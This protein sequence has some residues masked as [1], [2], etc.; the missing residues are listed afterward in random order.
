MQIFFKRKEALSICSCMLSLPGE[1]PSPELHCEK[2]RSHKCH[3]EGGLV[4]SGY[5]GNNCPGHSPGHPLPTGSG[6]QSRPLLGSDSGLSLKY[7]RLT[8]GVEIFFCDLPVPHSRRPL[9]D[10]TARDI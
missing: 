1:S 6:T 9:L 8:P 2:G 4:H 5:G 3:K 7:A 10:F